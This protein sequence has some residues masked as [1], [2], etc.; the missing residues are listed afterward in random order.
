M[1]RRIFVDSFGWISLI[2]KS[3][4]YHQLS[5]NLMKDLLKHQSKLITTDYILIE[6]INALSKVQFRQAVI[7]F[8]NRIESSQSVTII[9]ITDKI[10]RSAWELYKQRTDKEW[11]I[12]DCTCFEVME[13]FNLKKAFTKDR[14]FEQAGFNILL[15]E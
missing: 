3:D 13:M 2:N 12:T 5:A 4:N 8:V 14:H 6:T 11:G 7:E 1:N 15:K 9:K 10:Y